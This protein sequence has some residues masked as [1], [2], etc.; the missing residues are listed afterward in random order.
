MNN[1]KEIITE[2]NIPV[3]VKGKF[4]VDELGNTREVISFVYNCF[5]I[6]LLTYKGCRSCGFYNLR[7]AKLYWITNRPLDKR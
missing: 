7:L 1:K 6:P 3:E 4:F 5:G 2:Y